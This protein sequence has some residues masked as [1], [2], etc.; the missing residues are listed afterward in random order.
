MNEDVQEDLERERTMEE[1]QMQK[2]PPEVKQCVIRLVR[3]YFDNGI[4]Q[5]L[6]EYS[7]NCLANFST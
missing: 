3:M 1:F 7:I 5:I 4:F 2:S 6:T